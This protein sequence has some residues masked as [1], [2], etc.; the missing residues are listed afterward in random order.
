M[1]CK[2]S[3]HQSDR[4]ALLQF[5]ID[6]LSALNLHENEIEDLHQEHQMLHHAK[7]YLQKSQHIN[8]LLNCGG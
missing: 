6:E 4:I 3:E 2:I 7:E 5:Q 8:E 1:S